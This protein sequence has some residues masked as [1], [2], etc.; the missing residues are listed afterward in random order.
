MASGG[1]GDVLS[2]IVGAL[3]TQGLAAEAALT[4]GVFVHG[5]A[6]DRLASRV[7]RFGYLAG[8]VATE[9]PGAFDTIVR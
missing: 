1:M 9:L 3:M 8:D 2:G 5:Y 7:G 6:A 4:L